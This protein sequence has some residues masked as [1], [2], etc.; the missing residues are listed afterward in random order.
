MV[1]MDAFWSAL[2]KIDKAAADLVDPEKIKARE[3]ARQAEIERLTP[4]ILRKAERMCERAIGQ[5]MKI[6]KDKRRTVIGDIVA[7]EPAGVRV[8]NRSVVAQFKVTLE[9]GPSKVRQSFVVE[10]LPC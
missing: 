8:R 10:K 1:D 9:C 2:D 4:D 7:A 5:S 3:E 6:R